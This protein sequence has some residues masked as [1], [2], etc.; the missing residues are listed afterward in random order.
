MFQHPQVS[1]IVLVAAFAGI[2]IAAGVSAPRPAAANLSA[3]R[4]K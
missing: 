2:A 4:L 3:G 1:A